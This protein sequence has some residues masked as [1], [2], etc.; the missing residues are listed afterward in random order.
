MIGKFLLSAVMGLTLILTPAAFAELEVAPPSVT[1]VKP[2][3]VFSAKPTNKVPGLEL[4]ADMEVDH[5]EGFV[6]IE[7]TATGP[8][9]WLPLSDVK[10]KYTSVAPNAIILSVPPVNTT[11]SLF[12]V[13][14][15]DG[16]PTDFAVTNIKVVGA[17]ETN[18]SP[19]PTPDPTTG[20]VKL[21]ITFVLKLN[22]VT[23]AQAK[24]LNSA[25]LRKA[26]ADKGYYMR[27]YDVNSPII[28]QKKLTSFIKN[29][30]N[31]PTLIIQLP[32]GKVIVSKEMPTD[33]AEI[34]ELIEQRL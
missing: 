11:I 23:P 14:V 3:K 21:H 7:A 2:D 33:E 27:I 10:V 6:R 8:V 18:S 25:T 34:L 9:K 30:G 29:N 16:K 15:I 26:I 4:P 5:K 1:S 17:P 31:S 20:D 28:T 22:A 19:S 13:S 12:A 24:L 32:T